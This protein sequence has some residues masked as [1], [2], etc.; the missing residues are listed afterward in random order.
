MK[1][2]AIPM[3]FCLLGLSP[4][5]NFTFAQDCSWCGMD[6]APDKL[7]WST[8]IASAEEVGERLV[9]T[10]TVYQKD[11]H[12]PAPN[13]LIYVYHTNSEGLYPKRGDEHGNGQRHGYL[14]GWMQTDADGRYRFETI[15]PTP[16]RTHGGEPAHIHYTIQPPGEEEYWV[17]AAWFSDDPRVTD[18]S[19]A[20]LQRQGGFSNVMKLSR[21]SSGVWHGERKIVVAAYE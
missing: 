6:D 10:G 8:R 5:E 15:R 2:I 13:V 12:T 20:S 14:R 18:K 21:D 16:Y 4:A 19:V 17:N 7:S 1:N 3:F 9:V 11:G